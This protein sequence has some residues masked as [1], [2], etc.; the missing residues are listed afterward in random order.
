[1]LAGT[2]PLL[3][4]P[5]SFERPPGRRCAALAAAVL[6]LGAS[7][8]L[9]W[10]AP[11]PASPLAPGL[12]LDPPAL[13]LGRLPLGRTQEAKAR[14]RRTGP[15]TLKV[16]A[17]STGCACALVRGLPD[18]VAEG[19]S[20]TLGVFLAAR[21]RPGPLHLRVKVVTD[22]T[23][24][25]AP[26]GAD[27]VALDVAAYVGDRAVARP[28]RLD[29]GPRVAGASAERWVEVAVPPGDPAPRGATI[30]GLGGAVEVHPPA[31]GH[32]ALLRAVLA[33]PLLPGPFDGRL[34]VALGSGEA[35]EVP[36]GGVSVPGPP[37]GPGGG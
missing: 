24:R 35:L 3:L 19:A 36:V 20:G 32:G 12:V 27:L 2:H 37:C 22:A 7:A 4:L 33:V 34:V 21:D 9:P 17:V 25:G 16:L 31:T 23:R 14:W 30:R 8:L 10:P 28:A 29:L 13:D 26:A 6:V 5:G 18:E 11:R 15:G 1:V